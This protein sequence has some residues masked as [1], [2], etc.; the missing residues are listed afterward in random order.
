MRIFDAILISTN[1][2]FF[3]VWTYNVHRGHGSVPSSSHVRRCGRRRVRLGMEAFAPHPKLRQHR[4]FNVADM[5]AALAALDANGGDISR[6][7]RQTGVS[8]SA[9]HQWATSAAN[10]SGR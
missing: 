6:T 2:D 1:A 3:C 4:H 7:A 5:A 9:L 8:K 10:D